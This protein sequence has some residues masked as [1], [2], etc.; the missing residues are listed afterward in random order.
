[1][2]NVYVVR[3]EDKN[4]PRPAIFASLQQGLAR[5]GWSYTD[6]CDLSLV[7]KAL[8]D[9]NPT[10]EQN[11]AKRCLGFL[12]RIRQGDRLLYPNTPDRGQFAVCEV[13]DDEYLFLAP[14]QA[15]DGT[16]DFRSARRVRLLWEEPV[17]KDDPRVPPALRNRLGKQG[18]F[19]QMHDP[20]PLEDLLERLLSGLTP[21]QAASPIGLLHARLKTELEQI[22]VGLGAKIQAGHPGKDLSTFIQGLLE[23]MG[24]EPV[25]QE[26]PREYG[27]DL[28]VEIMHELLPALRVGIQVFSWQGE[29]AADSVRRKLDQLLAGWERNALDF[30]LLVTTANATVKAREMIR[31]H[32]EAELARRVRL[33][34]GHELSDL[35]I[36]HW[37]NDEKGEVTSG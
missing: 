25:L 27:S 36:R 28:V 2:S 21:E 18:R 4:G 6:A 14:E 20:S 17:S 7:K 32:N 24:Y 12:E 16:N 37:T 9:G 19:T 15:L 1:M 29:A 30:G 3:T 13:V 34:D 11:D 33:I 22:V 31:K 10:A 35:F 26:G 8:A 23:Q 5:I